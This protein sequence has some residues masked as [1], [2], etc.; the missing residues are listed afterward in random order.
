MAESLKKNTN[1]V[2]AKCDATANEIPGVEIKSF[3]TLKFYPKG[4]K[5]SPIEFNGERNQAGI[6]KWLKEKTSYPW[7]EADKKSDL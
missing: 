3:P 7:V 1:L 5:N 6:Y 2:I 4:K